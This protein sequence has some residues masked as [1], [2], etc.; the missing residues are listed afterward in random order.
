MP[1]SPI[2][3]KLFGRSPVSSLQA[4]MA[5]AAECAVALDAYFEL[6]YQENWH[7]LGNQYQ[8]ICDLEEQ[9]D[10]LKREIRLNLPRSLF[11]P[12]SR[13]DL[14]EL[15]R[16]QDEIPNRVKDIAGIVLGRKMRIPEPLQASFLEFVAASVN[17]TKKSHAMLEMLDQ[18]LDSGFSTR[19]VERI[20]TIIVE[21][22]ELETESDVKQIEIRSAL[23][24]LEKDMNPVDV[25]FLYRVLEWIGDVA[26]HAQTV[27]NRMLYVIA[28]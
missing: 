3:S 27:G 28:R 15:V 19:Q 13:S 25:M 21:L 4:H 5:K 22:G 2:F 18:L 9:A 6:L 20:E 26:D 23:F 7:E 12:V 1:R 11:L 14:L 10:E 16:V 24:E 17:A 8:K